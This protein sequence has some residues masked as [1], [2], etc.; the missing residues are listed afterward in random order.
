MT[1]VRINDFN[2]KGRTHCLNNQGRNLG[3]HTGTTKWRRMDNA[4]HAV[5]PIGTELELKD[6]QTKYANLLN[7][8]FGDKDSKG[9]Y[10]KDR[11]SLSNLK[12]GP[13]HEG[14][15]EIIEE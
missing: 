10:G 6:F 2:T 14:C 15:V 13:I 8:I 3:H 11:A 5:F 9:D 7:S 12:N 4:F 1:Q